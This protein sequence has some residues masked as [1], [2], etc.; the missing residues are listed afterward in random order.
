MKSMTNIIFNH[1]FSSQLFRAEIKLI[2]SCVYEQP[3]RLN[4]CCF[5]N[6]H[7]QCN[8]Y[9]QLIFAEKYSHKQIIQLEMVNITNGNRFKALI[10]VLF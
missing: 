4:Y 6:S 1:H 10:I 9:Q 5:A 7:L 8:G 2:C 3:F